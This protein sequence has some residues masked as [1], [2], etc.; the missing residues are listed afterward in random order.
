MKRLIV[1]IFLIFSPFVFAGS[2][3]AKISGVT[4]SSRTEVELLVGDVTGLISKITLKI[5]GKSYTFTPE[6]STVIKDND[7]DT[8]ILIAENDH[9]VFRMW[10]VPGSEKIISKSHGS[11]STRFA[12]VIEATDPRKG[13][14]WSITPRITI[15]CKL[16]YS[17]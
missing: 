15:G 13:D 1:T 10:M 7:S 8:Y 14:K 4:S 2:N 12:A 9:Y 3:D 11:L 17:I 5:D 16:N 6:D